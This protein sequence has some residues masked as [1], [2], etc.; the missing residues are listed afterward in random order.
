MN[1]TNVETLNLNDS[2]LQNEVTTTLSSP[3]IQPALALTRRESN[4]SRDNTLDSNLERLFEQP[5]VQTE[6]QRPRRFIP[7]QA[8]IYPRIPSPTAT[9]TSKTVSSFSDNDEKA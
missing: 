3:L 8:P 5:D 6:T 4:A 2:E 9:P 1:I 7:L